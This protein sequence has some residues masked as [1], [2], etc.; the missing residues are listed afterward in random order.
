[1]TWDQSEK[2]ISVKKIWCTL[3]LLAVFALTSCSVKQLPPAEWIYE[4]DAIRL[5]LQ[6]DFM[7]N[8]DQGKAHTLYIC[9][10]QLSDPNV[11][12]Q[13]SENREGLYKLLDCQLFDASAAASKR[14][15]VHP[16]EK[17]TLILDRAEDAKY[18][19]LVAGYYGIERERIT[20]L[21]EIPT[22][23]EKKGW[24]FKTVVQKPGFL[25]VELI[26]GPKQIITVGE[27][28]HNE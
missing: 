17:R 2:E 28:K 6:A 4:E 18:F 14:L 7:L 26:L 1:M 8:L 20:R 9:L 23:I 15:I 19:A 22:V 12:N 10:Y 11:F 21:I 27:F 16:G 25:D 5:K 13:L 3:A 24:F